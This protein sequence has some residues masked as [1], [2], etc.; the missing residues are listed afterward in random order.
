[1]GAGRDEEGKRGVPVERL[2]VDG[3]AIKDVDAVEGTEIT[4]MRRSLDEDA[5]TGSA[6]TS[7]TG[8]STVKGAASGGTPTIGATMSAVV[9]QRGAGTARD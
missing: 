2:L 7:T 9:A 4:G 1:M 5:T 3:P 6:E 8:M